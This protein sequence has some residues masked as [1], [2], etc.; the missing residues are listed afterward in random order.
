MGYSATGPPTSI[1]GGAPVSAHEF[2][3]RAFLSGLGL[4]VAGLSVVAA[5]AHSRTLG[6]PH[7]MS[8]GG[9]PAVTAS[10]PTFEHIVVLMLENRSFDHLFGW[11][12]RDDQLRLGQTV[13]GLY[14]HPSRNSAPDGSA[15]AA[16]A[17]TGTRESVLVQ[18]TTNAGEDLGH[19]TR[20][21][22]GTNIARGRPTMSGF[23]ADY[24]DNFRA[25][26]GR[27]P[28]PA[29][30]RQVMGGF[31]PDALP[32]L[33]T[34]ARR[35]GVFDH[36]F[37]SVPSNTFCNRSFFHA[38]TSNGF[39]TNAGSGGYSKWW[40][41]P[42]VPTVFNRLE[43]ARLAW[44]VYYDETQAV[45]ITGILSAPSIEPYWMSN[46]RG[47][48]QFH[49]DARTGNLAAYSFIEPRMIFNR[50]SLHPPT[51]AYANVVV[52][53]QPTYNKGVA[54]MLAGEELVAQVYESIR[55]SPAA[56]T[57]ALIITFD[58]TGGL[59]D[60]VP[61]PSAT[62]ADPTMP[63]EL[64]FAFDRLGCRVPAIFVSG[65]TDPGTVF[66]QSVDHTS[67]IATL[68]AQHGLAPLTDRDAASRPLMFAANRSTPRP[69]STWP[70]LTAPHVPAAPHST[71]RAEHAQTDSGLGIL[72]MLLDR[73][74]PAAPRPAN[75]TSAVDTLADLGPGLFGTTDT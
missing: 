5:V 47:M 10:L 69:A 19:V 65:W 6:D 37:A 17:Y 36:W 41:A 9:D 74:A 55:T 50:N 57:T 33:T 58:E 35:F 48:R 64:G 38:A 25:I 54:E 60:H 22:Y 15:V 28:S 70:I 4:G 63:G 14:Q 32:V 62:P 61:P 51:T 39:V 73:Y 1:P 49:S 34:L 56:D 72:G 7:A 67:V 2:S 43:D 27:D 52:D 23:V 75:L 21:L 12:Y 44:R 13:D 42:A 20:Q 45:S 26:R 66:N 40:N 59:F 71:T 11:L 18:P 24:A 8:E 3:R 68:S 16:Y 46:F 30:Y 31:A 53:D 29:E